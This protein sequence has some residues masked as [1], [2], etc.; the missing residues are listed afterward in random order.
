MN[1]TNDEL[2]MLIEGVQRQMGCQCPETAYWHCDCP[3]LHEGGDDD[4]ESL[5]NKLKTIKE[6][7]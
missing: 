7:K 6:S 5:L 1:F 4:K 2:K 3:Y